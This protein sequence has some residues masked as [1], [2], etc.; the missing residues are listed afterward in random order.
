[1]LDFA[2]LFVLRCIH[3][4]PAFK[5][6]ERIMNTLSQRLITWSET[7]PENNT[8]AL[9]KPLPFKLS[10]GKDQWSQILG[11]GT[12]P[13]TC[14]Q[15]NQN[16]FCLWNCRRS[17]VMRGGPR[18]SWNDRDFRER[19]LQQEHKKH[20][21]AYSKCKP[22]PG[23]NDPPLWNTI[24]SPGYKI[25]AAGVYLLWCQ[26]GSSS[27]RFGKLLS[28]GYLLSYVRPGLDIGQDSHF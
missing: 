6:Q 5:G 24:N 26:T 18:S 13:Q 14:F 27:G 15:C 16:T 3:K 11:P 7:E 9:C 10:V 21:V 22:T 19:Q 17:A 20:Q 23:D 8:K 25:S 12:R 28:W 1:M 4:D 2:C